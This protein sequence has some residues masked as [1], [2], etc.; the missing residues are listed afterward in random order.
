MKGLFLLLSICLTVSVSAQKAITVSGKAQGTYYV[1]KYLGRD[2]V[3]L[4]PEIEAI[5]RQ[6]DR[7]LSL[8]IPSSLINRFNKEIK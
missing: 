3:S 2:T 8:Y 1:V 7:S 5:F 6:I 4:Q